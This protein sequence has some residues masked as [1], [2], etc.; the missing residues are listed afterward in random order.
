MTSMRHAFQR[1]FQPFIRAWQDYQLGRLI[2]RHEISVM[3]VTE[4]WG[5][6]DKWSSCNQRMSED[7][8][9]NGKWG[10]GETPLEAVKSI[11]PTSK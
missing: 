2:R 10:G 11:L 9:H 5:A 8:G 7:Y 6:G 3:R 1:P 4:W